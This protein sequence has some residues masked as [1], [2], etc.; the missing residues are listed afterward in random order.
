MSDAALDQNSKQEELRDSDRDSMHILPLSILPIQTPALR[1][2]RLIKNAQLQGVVEIFDDIKTGSGQMDIE[3]LAIQFEWPKSPLHPDLVL[4]RQLGLMPSYDVYS[5]R[6]LLR[7]NDIPIKDLSALQLSEAKKKELTEY[8]TMFTRPLIAEIYGNQGMGIENFEQVMALFRNP[9]VKKAHA[10]LQL[11][12]EKLDV[13][14]MEIPKFLEDYG[15]VL[16]SL[17][18]YR[19]CL[20]DIEPIISTFLDCLTELQQNYQLKTDVNFVNTSKMMSETIN[21][22]MVAITGHFENFDIST[23]DMWN[24]ISAERFRAVEKVIRSYHTT[25]GGVLCALSVKMNAWHKIFPREDVGGPIKR[26]D[27][28]MSEMRQGIDNIQMI[29]GQ[30]L[31]MSEI[32]G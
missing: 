7:D 5:L 8:M 19:Q 26:S 31:M 18:Y 14:L 1:R 4:L 12:S 27:F 23:K 10:Q 16:L 3:S 20:D 25:I 15:D 22:L 28:I 24:D 9:D 29:E 32:F 2:A 6:V 30:A 13:E 21:G 11:M 17:S